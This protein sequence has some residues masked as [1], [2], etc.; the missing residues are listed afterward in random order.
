MLTEV[1]LVYLLTG[2]PRP[3]EKNIRKRK[4]R[5]EMGELDYE[6]RYA[7]SKDSHNTLDTCSIEV[8]VKF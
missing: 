2:N 6:W 8:R 3:K 1:D 7:E 4:V 5:A